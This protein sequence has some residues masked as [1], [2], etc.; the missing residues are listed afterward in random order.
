LGLSK[1][2]DAIRI[3]LN[4]D[5]GDEEMKNQSAF[6]NLIPRLLYLV[7]GALLGAIIGW[8][9]WWSANPP[10]SAKTAEVVVGSFSALTGFFF[11]HRVFGVLA[12]CF[13]YA[14]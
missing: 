5:E 2:N 8:I 4:D 7:V 13:L 14:P 10:F 12:R 1:I 9:F 11:G 6:R 3:P